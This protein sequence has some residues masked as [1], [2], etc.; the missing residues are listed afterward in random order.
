LSALSSIFLI[1]LE[2]FFDDIYALIVSKINM[3]GKKNPCCMAAI[4]IY[5]L[6]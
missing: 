4:G 2:V 6:Y 3:M 1:L 5:K